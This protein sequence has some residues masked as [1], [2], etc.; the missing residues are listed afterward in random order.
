MNVFTHKQCEIKYC[1][2]NHNTIYIDTI[3]THITA[4]GTGIGTEAIELFIK[5][6]SNYN[7]SLIAHSDYNQEKLLEWYKRIG[8]EIVGENSFGCEMVYSK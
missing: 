6:H 1:F 7:I 8:F 5:E 2:E 4:R 3:N